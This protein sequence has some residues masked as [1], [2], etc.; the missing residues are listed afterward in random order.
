MKKK[1]K[2]KEKTYIELEVEKDTNIIPYNENLS[3][4]NYFYYILHIQNE[5]HCE[6][7]TVDNKR[8]KDNDISF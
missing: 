4:F 3:I 6:D 5:I 2:E 7:W 1:K 8:E